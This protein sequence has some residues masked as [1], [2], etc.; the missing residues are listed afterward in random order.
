MRRALP[1]AAIAALVLAVLLAG[2]LSPVR[3]ASV[4]SDALGPDNGEQVVDYLARAAGSLEAAGSLGA[5]D[6][7]RW[8]LVSFDAAQRVED[9]VALPGDPRVGRILFKVPISRVQTPLVQVPVSQ[10]VESWRRAPG[11][12]AS[13]LH[14]EGTGEDRRARAAAVSAERL[15]AGCACVI[16]L[17][18]RA[19]TAVLA[20]IAA[21]D[22]VRAVEA[23][24]AD[25]VAGRFSVSPLL[26]EHVDVVLPGPD[27]GEL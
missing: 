16:G 12:A 25:A 2:W 23:L 19:P 4:R 27:D 14:P 13:R 10:H 6:D 17:V 11:V 15:A 7:P 3:P 22:G 24:P 18:V 21:T 8:A 1:W 20:D 9:A 26:P 5:G